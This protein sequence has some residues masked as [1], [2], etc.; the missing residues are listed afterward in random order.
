MPI[1]MPEQEVISLG[2]S[3]ITPRETYSSS[4]NA[5]NQQYADKIRNTEHLVHALGSLS[6]SF[7]AIQKKQQQSADE[8]AVLLQDSVDIMSN[9]KTETAAYNGN[10]VSGLVSGLFSGGSG[11]SASPTVQAR[12]A[13]AQGEKEFTKFAW[14]DPQMQR[15]LSDGALQ[16]NPAA[17]RQQFEAFLAN[18]REQFKQQ[19]YDKYGANHPFAKVY[20]GGF[21]TASRKLI[22]GLTDNA[23]RASAKE[24]QKILEDQYDGSL[25]QNANQT[26]IQGMMHVIPSQMGV[27]P[28]IASQYAAVE[29]PKLIPFAKAGTPAGGLPSSAEGLMQITDARWADIKK[30]MA[31][32][33]QKELAEALVNRKD[34]QQNLIA[35]AWDYTNGDLPKAR[36]ILGREPKTAETYLLWNAGSGDGGKLLSA[37]ASGSSASVRDI[38][39]STTIK[40]NPS[41]YGDGSATA[42]EVV[43]HLNSKMKQGSIYHTRV[44]PVSAQERH[45][46]TE[47]TW[48]D[49]PKWGYTWNEVSPSAVNGQIDS[50][51]VYALQQLSTNMGRKLVVTQKPEDSQKAQ[52]GSITVAMPNAADKEKAIKFLSALGMSDIGVGDKTLTFK[53]SDA[54]KEGEVP[55]LRLWSESAKFPEEKVRLAA[56]DSKSITDGGN[57]VRASGFNG[58]PMNPYEAMI[59]K[60][61]QYGIPPSVAKDKVLQSQISGSLNKAYAKDWTGA[62]QQIIAVETGFPNL[63]EQ[64]Q[65]KLNQAKMNVLHIQD[66]YHAADKQREARQN[67]SATN[68][69]I[70]QALANPTI[71]VNVQRSMFTSTQA[72]AKAFEDAQR[73][74]ANPSP[75]APEISA[76]AVNDLTS[77]IESGRFDHE[78]FDG[79]PPPTQQ[80]MTLALTRKRLVNLADAQKVAGQYML[81][82]QQLPTAINTSQTYLEKLAKPD[83]DFVFSQN[84]KAMTNLNHDVEAQ[85][86]WTRQ[87]RLS[88]V[89]TPVYKTYRESFEALY[90]RQLSV[91]GTPPDFKELEVINKLAIESAKA[92]AQTLASMWETNSPKLE[93]A[94]QRRANMLGVMNAQEF[95]TQKFNEALQVARQRGGGLNAAAPEL[96]QGATLIVDN[97][98]NPIRNGDAFQFRLPQGTVMEWNPVQQIKDFPPEPPKPV[99]PQNQKPI[100]PER[101]AST[102]TP[103]HEMLREFFK[104]GYH[105]MN[106]IKPEDTV[107]GP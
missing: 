67:E 87:Q 40:N 26:Q 2:S 14:T 85:D 6:Q 32:S 43:A 23:V 60:G 37:I 73:L 105:Y 66:A 82:K 74:A 88:S 72:G 69:V 18:K 48:I 1:I 39:G 71:P 47:N 22:D 91:K 94:Q 76:A 34:P 9:A 49:T 25:N 44:S 31:S 56:N 36:A 35:W 100:V 64:D 21:D 99:V 52:E 5:I 96:P 77:R 95:A 4:V 13:N 80:E 79:N 58:A 81:I 78:I 57:Y 93:D 102:F 15:F 38:V 20:L 97:K 8:N 62:M 103:P 89:M 63:S 51:N 55:E 12:L 30:R 104:Q 19:A 106:N 84:V 90:T 16:T 101:P 70:E 11:V 7:D 53:V 29:N 92:Q 68:I 65:Q 83:L 75:L 24:A 27:D 50:R 46:F 41:V 42:Q 86:A 59:Q 33:G 45:S 17:W 3:R 61:S 54:V 107:S 10:P 98:G 28:A